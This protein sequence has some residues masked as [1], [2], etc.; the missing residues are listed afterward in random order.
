MLFLQELIIKSNSILTLLRNACVLTC[1]HGNFWILVILKGIPGVKYGFWL[2]DR[3]NV[4]I[5]LHINNIVVIIVFSVGL[6]DD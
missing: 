1:G 4:H 5:N 2:L 3:S 6:F